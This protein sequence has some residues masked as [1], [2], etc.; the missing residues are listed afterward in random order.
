MKS[1]NIKRILKT[2]YGR[3][4]DLIDIF[5]G[6]DENATDEQIAAEINKV[7]TEL[8]NDPNP[9]EIDLD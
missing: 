8:E 1:E 4:E 5:P 6:T 3:E 7:L 2:V 9:T